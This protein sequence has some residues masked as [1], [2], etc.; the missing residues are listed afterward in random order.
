VNF[1]G[2]YRRV[3]CRRHQVL[4]P[5]HQAELDATRAQAL[6]QRAHGLQAAGVDVAVNGENERSRVSAG[7]GQAREH[8]AP[9]VAGLTRLH[10]YGHAQDGGF[11]ACLGARQGQESGST[12]GQ[13]RASRCWLV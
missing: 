5:G 11:R 4:R 12:H 6:V 7:F 9:Q 3:R 13:P 1:Q 10:R 2:A 8:R